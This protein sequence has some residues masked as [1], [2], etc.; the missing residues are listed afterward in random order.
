MTTQTIRLFPSALPQA[1]R[2]AP[3]PAPVRQQHLQPATQDHAGI[4]EQPRDG[5]VDTAYGTLRAYRLHEQARAH[6]SAAVAQMIGAGLRSLAA[7]LGRGLDAYR[8]HSRMRATYHALSQLDASTL[9][10]LGFHRSEL[11]SVAAEASGAVNPTRARV[12]AQRRQLAARAYAH[13]TPIRT[14]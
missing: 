11:M 10:D 3:Q 2:H 9:R 12:M 8:R 7:M 4:L 5:E 13:G 6:R 1:R 14:P